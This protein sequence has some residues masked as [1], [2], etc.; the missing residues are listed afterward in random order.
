MVE[1]SD[2]IYCLGRLARGVKA[3]AIPFAPTSIDLRTSKSSFREHRS[4]AD[5]R[6]GGW[7][8]VQADA[9]GPTVYLGPVK[10]KLFYPQIM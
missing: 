5:K 9:A 2:L 3:A 4:D 7:V 10:V 8:R 1:F 6:A